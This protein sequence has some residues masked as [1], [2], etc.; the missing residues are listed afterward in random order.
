MEV[1]LDG[2]MLYRDRAGIGRY[3][4]ELQRALAQQPESPG[5]GVTLLVDPR[6]RVSTRAALPV[7][8]VLAPSRHALERLV[9]PLQLRRYGVAHFPDHGMPPGVRVGGVVTV[10]DL[11]FLNLPETHDPRSRAYYL[12][13]IGTLVRA[14]RIIAVSAY[15]QQGILERRLAPE[16]RVTVIHQAPAA[17]LVQT[18]NNENAGARD[19][20]YCLIVATI[21][22]RK[23]L[24]R[25]AAAFVRTRTAADH[26]LLIV[27]ALGY[28]G[29]DI[30]RQI[31]DI[32]RNG[33]VHIVGRLTD[34]RMANLIRHARLLLMPSLEEGFGLPA[35]DAM[36]LG[37]PC[38]VSDAGAMPEVTAGAARLIDPWDLDSIAAA[39]DAVAS[40]DAE[41]QRL[42]G[43]GRTR[44]AELSW[45]QTATATAEVYREAA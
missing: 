22:P 31:R 12:A 41:R 42:I 25:A 1:A 35:V 16:S 7:R 33:R 2:R 17:E 14:R 32:D 36:A 26:D 39:V 6:D 5:P 3:I 34:E 29:P 38:V 19:R 4:W 21:Q 24:V 28:R 30:A 44:A 43:L 37:V 13:A 23:N 9:L 27:G 40:D 8:R 10:H 15:V 11:S 45:S 18:G 20:P